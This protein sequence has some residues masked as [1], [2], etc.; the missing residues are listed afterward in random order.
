MVLT[1]LKN[2]GWNSLVGRPVVGQA[3]EAA[4]RPAVV[5]R[6]L[7]LIG[8]ANHFGAEENDRSTHHGAEP[9]RLT[10]V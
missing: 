1:A 9:D 2:D 8:S 4:L 6:Q 10:Q 3:A 7:R 5:G